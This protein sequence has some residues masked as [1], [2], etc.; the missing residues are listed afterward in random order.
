MKFYTLMVSKKG[1]LGLVFKL[2]VCDTPPHFDWPGH[3]CVD[4]S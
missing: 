4:M 2:S 1:I 3:L